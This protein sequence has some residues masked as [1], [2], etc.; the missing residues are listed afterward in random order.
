MIEMDPDL[1]PLLSSANYSDDPGRHS[2]RQHGVRFT[3]TVRETDQPSDAGNTRR[4]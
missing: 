2:R 4:K 1:P 3:Q